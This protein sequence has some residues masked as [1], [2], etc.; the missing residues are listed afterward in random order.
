[1]NSIFRKHALGG[2]K[3]HKDEILNDLT[4]FYNFYWLDMAAS[5]TFM[6]EDRIGNII[7]L[8]ML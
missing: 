1:M 5:S 6:Q 7:P 3:E 4:F 8:K 2:T